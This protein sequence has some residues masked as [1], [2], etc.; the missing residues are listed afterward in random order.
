M[1]C[2]WSL[3]YGV[4]GWQANEWTSERTSRGK[5]TIFFIE[6]VP[7]FMQKK[8]FHEFLSVINACI[9]E[10]LVYAVVW[11]LA[12]TPFHTDAGTHSH[13]HTIN[14]MKRTFPHHSSLHSPLSQMQ[15]KMWSDAD[16]N[17]LACKRADSSSLS[18]CIVRWFSSKWRTRWTRRR[19]IDGVTFK[20]SSSSSITISRQN[21]I[22][23][24]TKKNSMDCATA[25]WTWQPAI[26][27]SAA[28][29]I[30]ISIIC[31]FNSLVPKLFISGSFYL[32]FFLTELNWMPKVEHFPAS[33]I[34]SEY[35][36]HKRFDLTIASCGV[37]RLFHV[38]SQRLSLTTNWT[39]TNTHTYT[40][41]IN[42]FKIARGR[43]S[44]GFYFSSH[45]HHAMRQ[46]NSPFFG[47]AY[48]WLMAR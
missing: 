27:V 6:F 10:K 22:H 14:E 8:N 37:R 31:L 12:P 20:Y 46:R 26:L 48:A 25:Y 2:L 33:N 24:F 19:R 1:L 3:L 42:E 38:R 16:I 36:K 11:V 34:S 28:T 29:A 13:T 32:V 18:A 41:K 43:F 40:V 17:K 15:I 23:K 21:V 45:R 35:T 4:A 7:R 5:K 47:V 44:R 9:K 30:I 39:Q